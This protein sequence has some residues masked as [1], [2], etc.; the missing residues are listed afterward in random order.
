[1]K[2]SI[3]LLVLSLV[4]IATAGEKKKLP[5]GYYLEFNPDTR[6]YRWCRDNGSCSVYESKTRNGAIDAAVK[7]S[8]IE[9]RVEGRNWERVK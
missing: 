1:M 6:F 9:Y 2:L 4:T 7:Q 8:E 5:E 3:I